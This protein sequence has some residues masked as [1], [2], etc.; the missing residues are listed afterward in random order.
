MASVTAQIMVRNEPLLI[1]AV[2]AVY[3][4]V[5]EVMLWD[6]GSYDCHTLSDIDQL[7][8]EDPDRKL[9]VKHVKIEVDETKWNVRTWHQ[10]QVRGRGKK[11]KGVVRK[12]MLD[13]TK[14]DWFLIVDGDEIH[15]NHGIKTLVGMLDKVSRQTLVVGIPLLWLCDRT[16]VFRHSWS[17]RAFRTSDVGIRTASPNEMHTNRKTGKP[18]EKGSKSRVDVD[19]D[20]YLHYET[21][22]KPWRRPVPKASVRTLTRSEPFVVRSDESIMKR[23]ERENAAS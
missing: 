5:D 13:A 3:P 21:M 4:H 2:R 8:A 7:R 18:I 15:Y 11:T 12:Q 6:T 14:T 16:H 9:H 23:W 22:L 20:A 17:G 19:V 1:Y 10:M